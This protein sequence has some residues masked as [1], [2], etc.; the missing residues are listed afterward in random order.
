MAESAGQVQGSATLSRLSKGVSSLPPFP[1]INRNSYIGMA[2]AF[3]KDSSS[4]FKM[5]IDSLADEISTWI[6]KTKPR[7]LPDPNRR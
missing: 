7:Q 4:A 2:E 3:D 6:L 1:Y 5:R